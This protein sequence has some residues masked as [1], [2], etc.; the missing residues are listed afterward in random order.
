METTANITL[1]WPLLIYGVAVILLIGGML[2]ISHFIG[3]RHSEKATSEPFES[4]VIPT[5]SARLHFPI[6]FYIVA[7]FFVV[8]DLEA[9]FIFIWAISLMETGWSGYIVILL[10]IIELMIVLFYLWKIGALDFGP[11]SKAILKAY[12]KKIKTD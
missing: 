4:G 3:E 6:H 9:V 8:F 1:L 5:G 10:F 7:M 12:H 2:V 11:N